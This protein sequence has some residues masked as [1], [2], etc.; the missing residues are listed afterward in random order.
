MIFTFRPAG[1]DPEFGPMTNIHDTFGRLLG[2]IEDGQAM[3][4]FGTVVPLGDTKE[5]TASAVHAAWLFDVTA[6]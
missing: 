5:A 3:T 4:V 6:S 2:H 1:V